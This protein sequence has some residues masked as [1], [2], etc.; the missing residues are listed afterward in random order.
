MLP[1][2]VELVEGQAQVCSMSRMILVCATAVVAACSA[3]QPAANYDAIADQLDRA[4]DEITP[5]L[6]AT[7]YMLDQRWL[8]DQPGDENRSLAGSLTQL[9]GVSLGPNGQVHVRGQ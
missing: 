2:P 4:R 5:P 7:T 6:G 8:L 3:Q 1:S 9:P